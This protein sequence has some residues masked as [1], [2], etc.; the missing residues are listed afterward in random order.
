MV[1]IGTLGTSK[2]GSRAGVAPGEGLLLRGRNTVSIQSI[3]RGKPLEKWWG[4]GN[5]QLAR[6]FFYSSLR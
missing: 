4:R 2:Y 1:E 6:F 5:F 3:I